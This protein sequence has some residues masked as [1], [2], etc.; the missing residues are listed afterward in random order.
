MSFEAAFKIDASVQ[1]ILEK[2]YFDLVWRDLCLEEWVYHYEVIAEEHGRSFQMT[3]SL[4]P[5]F[6]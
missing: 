6:R 3:K 4:A 5:T 1:V 2:F